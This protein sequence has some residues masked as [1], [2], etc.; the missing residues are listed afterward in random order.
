ML[1]GDTHE[2][3]G[4][5]SGAAAAAHLGPLQLHRLPGARS[6]D[7]RDWNIQGLPKNNFSTEN[8][9][10]S[11]SRWPLMIDPQGPGSATWTS[12]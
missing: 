9:L 3:V 12:R 1:L 7:V 6:T 8:G 5:L 10:I 2:C 11:T 4:R